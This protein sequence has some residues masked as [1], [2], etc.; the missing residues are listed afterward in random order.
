MQGCLTLTRFISVKV[1]ISITINSNLFINQ[2]KKKIKNRT[3]L[4][5][6]VR[7]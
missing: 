4:P 5:N 3:I 2:N 7:Q 1:S 6:L